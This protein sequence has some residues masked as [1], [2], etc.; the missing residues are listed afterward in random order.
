[1]GLLAWIMTKLS[2]LLKRSEESSIQA[3]R[4]EIAKLRNENR[5]L[6]EKVIVLPQKTNENIILNFYDENIEEVIRKSIR[7]AKEELCIAVAWFT[8]EI[9]M[10][11]LSRLKRRGVNVKIIISD[12][13]KNNKSIYKL[14]DSCNQLIV[15]V[16]PKKADRKYNNIM[17]NKYC[18]ID[19]N[20]VID[21]SYNWTYSANYNLE[22]I[23]LIESTEIAKLYKTN[24]EKIY[25]HSEYYKHSSVHDKLG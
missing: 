1:M 14:I 7:E 21:G 17:H 5:I 23:I 12:D 20:K 13:N 3:L 2:V 18:I 24:F 11:E 19:N 25:N 6:K 9:L 10:E 16:I 22:H 15:P 4:K 8:S